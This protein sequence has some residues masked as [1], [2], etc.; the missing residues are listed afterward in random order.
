MTTEK[1]LNLTY[2][3]RDGHKIHAF[4]NSVQSGLSLCGACFLSDFERFGVL[5]SSVEEIQDRYVR[6]NLRLCLKCEASISKLKAA[7]SKKGGQLE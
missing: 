2:G 5:R 1:D 6:P 7:A 3:R 4:N